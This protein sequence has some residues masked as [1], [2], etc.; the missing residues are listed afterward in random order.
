MNGFLVTNLLERS[1]SAIFS[2][3]SKTD[4]LKKDGISLDS[5]PCDPCCHVSDHCLISQHESCTS[6]D[7]ELR[8]D[9]NVI[10]YSRLFQIL[11]HFTFFSLVLSAV[12]TKT[13]CRRTACA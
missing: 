1:M 10:S 11:K 6:V 2:T 4:E 13:T 5:N 9:F 8:N 12:V 3:Q 7:Y